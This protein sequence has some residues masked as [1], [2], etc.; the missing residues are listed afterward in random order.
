MD[1]QFNGGRQV[2]GVGV[3]LSYQKKYNLG[4]QYVVYA[5]GATWDPLRDRD[6]ISVNANVSF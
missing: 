2:L 6:Y 1:G 3:N 4:V 5:N